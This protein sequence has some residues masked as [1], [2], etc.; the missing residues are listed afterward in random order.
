MNELETKNFD[1][2]YNCI[3]CLEDFTSSYKNPPLYC[4]KKCLNEYHKIPN[5]GSLKSEET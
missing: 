4:S 2:I 1:H 3:N 5:G